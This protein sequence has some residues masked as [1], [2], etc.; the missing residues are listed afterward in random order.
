[1]ATKNAFKFNGGLPSPERQAQLVQL[2]R[3]REAAAHA[4]KMRTQLLEATS[5]ANR[6]QLI[7]TLAREIAKAEIEEQ[8]HAKRSKAAKKGV[9]T[10]KARGKRGKKDEYLLNR[11]IVETLHK[12]SKYG[13]SAKQASEEVAKKNTTKTGEPIYSPKYIQNILGKPKYKKKVMETK[14]NV[15]LAQ[16]S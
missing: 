5:H 14:L 4:D 1:M 9:R 15:K 12:M 11:M 10:A 13:I 6:D 16:G 8:E 7:K 3:I 2:A